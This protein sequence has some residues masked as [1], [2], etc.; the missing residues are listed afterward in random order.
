MIWSPLLQNFILLV[1]VWG[2]KMKRL[3]ILLFLFIVLVSG[4]KTL[5][6]NAKDITIDL[7]DPIVK[8]TAGF[9]GTDLLI[10]GV[11]PSD[12]DIVVVIRGPIR[13]EI[14]R[15]KKRV[16]GVWVNRDQIIL[17]NAPTLYMMASNRSLDQFLPGGIAYVHQIGLENIH[18]KPRK[19]YA[20]VKNWEHFRHA[21]IRNKVNQNLYKW[22]PEPLVFL[23]NR[24]FRTKIHFPANLSV[25]TFGIDTYLISKGEMVAFE[26][27]LLNVRKFGVEAEVYNF[28]HRHSF[29]YGLLAIIVAGL[30]GW[31]ANAVFRKA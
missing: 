26:T 16:M 15:Q 9:S 19:D 14:I 31:V 17:E 30:A 22:D 10:F 2:I 13:E 18:I 24:L 11:A 29:A 5:P 1:A 12:G 27:T 23:G 21:L 28:A 25:G 4:I 3:F 8:I 6:A 7:S 20:H